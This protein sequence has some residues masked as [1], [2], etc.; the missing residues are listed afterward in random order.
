MIQYLFC[1]RCFV[2]QTDVRKLAGWGPWDRR[3]AGHGQSVR[4]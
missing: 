4:V 3:C 2:D 1:E